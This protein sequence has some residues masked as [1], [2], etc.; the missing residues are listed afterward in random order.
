MT[1][2][3]RFNLADYL[4]TPED[5]AAYRLALAQERGLDTGAWPGIPTFPVGWD[6]RDAKGV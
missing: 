1:E 5:W 2:T 6:E 3:R 4:K